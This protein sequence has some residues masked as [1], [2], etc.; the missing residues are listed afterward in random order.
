MN[1]HAYVYTLLLMLMYVRASWEH[2]SAHGPVEIHA[3]AQ[4]SMCVMCVKESLDQRLFR[5]S[6][7]PTGLGIA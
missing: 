3:R 7:S 1:L 6:P 5:S 2:A 4:A